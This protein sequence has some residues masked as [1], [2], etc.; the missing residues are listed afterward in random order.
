MIHQCFSLGDALILTLNSAVTSTFN[1]GEERFKE[2]QH[3]K[4]RFAKAQLANQVSRRSTTHI[5]ALGDIE[6]IN[7]DQ[8]TNDSQKVEQI[9]QLIIQKRVKKPALD[10]DQ[11]RLI[12]L[13]KVNQP[14]SNR[15]DYYKSLEKESIKIYNRVT[16]IVVALVFDTEKSQ[17]DI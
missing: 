2:E 17:K 3:Y 10:E 13:K 12:E 11:Q 4:N 1:D 15:D 6:T 9:R 16:H 8:Q 5:H 14:I 7:E